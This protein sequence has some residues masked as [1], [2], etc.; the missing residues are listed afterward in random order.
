MPEPGGYQTLEKIIGNY[1]GRTTPTKLKIVICG[2]DSTVSNIAW[3][4]AILR[5]TKPDV[6]KLLDMSFYILP[7]G[8]KNRFATALAV[9]DQW[10][11]RQVL[12]ALRSVMWVVPSFIKL[13]FQEKAAPEIRAP[14]SSKDLFEHKSSN[15]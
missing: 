14:T 9:D 8:T 6:F 1:S 2:G 15:A 3:A 12:L 7:T 4:Y 13:P 10:Y 5:N 11:G